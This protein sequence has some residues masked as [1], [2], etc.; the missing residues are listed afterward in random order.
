MRVQNRGFTLIETLAATAILMFG[1][2]AVASAFGYCAG[3]SLQ[4]Q[5]RAAA[6]LLLHDKME[7]LKWTPLSGAPWT[8]GGGLN[9]E[10]PAAGFSEYVTQNGVT[11]LRMW[12][13]SGTVPRT[14]TVAVYAPAASWR[15][16][17]MEMVRGTLVS[18]GW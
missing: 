17:P 10:A 15:P 4:N 5:Q 7:Q 1:L 12:Q 2:A 8:A 16:R 14:A 18:A 9:S 3:A 13:I 11:F 6:T